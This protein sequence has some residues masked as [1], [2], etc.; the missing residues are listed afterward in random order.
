MFHLYF[1]KVYIKQKSIQVAAY[2][3]HTHRKC[4]LVHF[5]T[6]THTTGLIPSNN[7]DPNCNGALIFMCIKYFIN[8]SIRPLIHSKEFS[9]FHISVHCSK[10]VKLFKVHF[11][12]YFLEKTHWI[13][14]KEKLSLHTVVILIHKCIYVWIYGDWWIQQEQW[15]VKLRQLHT[16]CDI[17]VSLK[18]KQ[19]TNRTRALW[20]LGLNI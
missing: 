20:A 12:K 18:E 19:I 5:H 8:S 11:K 13:L 9:E 3:A 17:L 15:K 10:L 16:W 2:Y 14:M 7:N 4:A 6:H 1:V